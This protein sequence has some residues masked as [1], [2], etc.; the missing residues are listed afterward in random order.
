EWALEARGVRLSIH[1]RR[2]FQH[3]AEHLARTIASWPRGF[4][5]RDYQSRNLMVVRDAQ[6]HLGL[7]WID[8]QDAML[9]PRIYDLVALLSDSYQEFDA[10]FIE[11]RLD[12]YAEHSGLAA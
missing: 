12:E 10:D 11:E 9:G 2:I 4:V 1:D 8:F 6:G 5:H 7:G 3:S